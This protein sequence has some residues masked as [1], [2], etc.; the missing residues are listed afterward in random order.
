MSYRSLL[1]IVQRHLLSVSVWVSGSKFRE[2]CNKFGTHLIYEWFVIY[3]P[4]SRQNVSLILHASATSNLWSAS[5]VNKLT[6]VVVWFSLYFILI[7]RDGTNDNKLDM[8]HF[9]MVLFLMQILRH[10][11]P[12]TITPKCSSWKHYHD[13]W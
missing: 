2:E 12:Q 4:I 5:F 7:R 6:K 8:H 11:F 3:E 9:K 1:L 13:N 10:N